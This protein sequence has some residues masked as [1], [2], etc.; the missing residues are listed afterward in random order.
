MQ[1]G[2]GKEKAEMKQVRETR[3]NSIANAR[4]IHLEKLSEENEL[5][6]IV[7]DGLNCG[8]TG[9]ASALETIEYF[10]TL[11]KTHP[12]R[13]DVLIVARAQTEIDFE[14]LKED[15]EGLNC[16]LLQRSQDDDLAVLLNAEKGKSLIVTNDRFSNLEDDTLKLAGWTREEL[17][18]HQAEHCLRNGKFSL[19]MESKFKKLF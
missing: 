6:S 3:K 14:M 10:D 13:F 1:L 5:I 4:L 7:I 9:R 16:L 12:S 2:Q 19:L 18:A 11:G 15:M 8:I 17:S